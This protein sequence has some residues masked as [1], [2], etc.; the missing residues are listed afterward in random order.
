MST[1][2]Y[3]SELFARGGGG[4]GGGGGSRWADG[5]AT[6]SIETDA[7]SI[8]LFP[9]TGFGQQMEIK[10]AALSRD[11]LAF[12]NRDAKQANFFSFDTILHS[13]LFLYYKI[14]ESHI[15]NKILIFLKSIIF[16][17]I[18]FPILKEKYIQCRNT[19]S[20]GNI[21]F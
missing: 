1:A 11:S 3:T 20:A 18:N 2:Y 19:F 13:S 14:N 6:G 4:G 15:F 8:I 7:T 9:F 10:H 5:G 17:K 16:N 12:H 21:S